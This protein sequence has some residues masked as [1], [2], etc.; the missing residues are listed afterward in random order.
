MSFSQNEFIH[1]VQI[2]IQLEAMTSLYMTKT[3]H[4]NFEVSR[5]SLKWLH[6]LHLKCLCTMRSVSTKQKFDWYVSS[7]HQLSVKC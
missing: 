3:F 5:L 2:T 6:C 4:V 1:G 7:V